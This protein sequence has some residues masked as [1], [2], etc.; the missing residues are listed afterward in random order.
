MKKIWQIYTRILFCYKIPKVEYAP[1]IFKFIILNSR[2][3]ILG[4]DSKI[5]RIN[6]QSNEKRNM[7]YVNFDLLQFQKN[8]MRIFKEKFKNVDFGLQMPPFTPL[9]A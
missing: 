8:I 7:W 1:S 9:W 4:P 3:E 2:M 5:I 6:E